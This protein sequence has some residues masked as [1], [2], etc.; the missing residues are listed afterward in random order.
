MDPACGSGTF[1]FHLVR[2]VLGAADTSGLSP[3]A[4]ARRAME[5]VAGID[6]HPV[7]VIFARVTYLLALMPALRE[8][9]PGDLTLPVY[10]G[11][12]LQWNLARRGEQG[13]QPGLFASDQTLEIFVPA[14]TMTKPELRRLDAATLRFPATVAA[15]TQLFDRVLGNMIGFG[16]R[17]ESPANFA[18][19]MEREISASDEDRCVLRKTYEVMRR[20]QNE[21]RNHIWGY[22][23]RNLARPVWLAS[24]TQK[25]D[26][27]IGNPPW[28][29]FRYMSMDF[30]KRFRDECRTAKLW[31]G[32]KVAT[33]QDLA[34]YFYIRA[35]LLYMRRTGRI[36]LVMPY[37]A[38]SRQSYAAFRKGEVAQARHVAFR[39]LFTEAWVFGPDVQPLFPVPSGVLFAQVHDGDAAAPLPDRVTAFSG[40]L[41][42]RDA[43]E[44][45]ADANLTEAAATWPTEASEQGG[46]ALSPRIPTRRN[47]GAPALSACRGRAGGRNAPTP[48]CVSLGPRANRQ[49][50]QGALEDHGAAARHGGEGFSVSSTARGVNRPVP[51]PDAATGYHPMGRGETSFAGC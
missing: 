10:L 34:S 50:G 4:A 46:V 32:G 27:V 26:I 5:K 19:W 38:M 23:A 51:Y 45:E 20:L 8:E 33:Q 3:A 12:A 21:G 16:E 42:R 14:I 41:P 40:M 37:A 28:V 49:A 7:A 2:A 17:S 9:H 44:S 25:A 43:G 36:A 15:D 18:A 39:L 11:D 47:L 29:S 31:V 1:L 22:V 13:E 24:E 6:I 35:A 48:P 30:K